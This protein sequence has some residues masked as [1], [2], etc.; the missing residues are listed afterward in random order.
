MAELEEKI[1]A[2]VAEADRYRQDFSER[3][4]VIDAENQELLTS[5][6][7]LKVLRNQIESLSKRISELDIQKAEHKVK[8]GTLHEQ[9]R[10]NYGLAIDIVEV[11]SLTA[12]DEKRLLDLREK[13]QE[14]G[15][16]NLGPLRN[17]RNYARVMN[18][19]KISRK[20]STDLL[21]NSKRR[22]QG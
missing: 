7:G 2:L 4:E 1:K 18:S 22:S 5:D 15:P 16:V 3:K 11:E 8:M 19:L 17:M 13:I 21:Q 6:Q 10:Q 12:E 9:I 20:T 14:L